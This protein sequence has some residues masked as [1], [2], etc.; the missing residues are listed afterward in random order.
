MWIARLPQEDFC[1]ATG[2]PATQKYEA[3]GGPSIED[4]LEILAGSESP[5][6]DREHFVLAQ[7]AFWLLA[8]T[9][10]HA[11]NFSLHQRAGGTFG[12]TPLYDVLSAWPVIGPG[13]NQLPIQDAKLAMSIRGR[14][15]H[16]RL[17]E[18]Q[19]RHW[20]GLA[21]RVGVPE[22]WQR[23]QAMVATADSKVEIVRGRL[24]GGFP[25]RVMET[26]AK[27]V[28]QQ[29]KTFLAGNTAAA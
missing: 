11:K 5:D 23:M 27:G 8:A 18:I 14:S 4:V 9:D 20:H 25:K 24:P 19:A 3:D 10:G 1:Q 26:I 17:K 15:R 29:A 28:R 2:R 22:L 21:S 7:L 16:Y 13:A 6:A 12:M